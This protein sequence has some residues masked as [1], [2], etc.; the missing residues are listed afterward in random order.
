MNSQQ[1]ETFVFNIKKNATSIVLH[2]WKILKYDN[3][4]KKYI[5]FL[6]I[7]VSGQKMKF[8]DNTLNSYNL[9]LC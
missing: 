3:R 7:C 6:F 1:N 4:R 2:V 5:S 9:R 8:G